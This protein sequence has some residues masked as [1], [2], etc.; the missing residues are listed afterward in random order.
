MFLIGASGQGALLRAQNRR[1]LDRS[2]PLRNPFPLW[3][4]IGEAKPFYHMPLQAPPWQKSDMQDS[5]LYGRILGIRDP[6][7]VERVDLQLQHGEVHVYL[8]HDDKP[9]W[10][11]AECGASCPSMI[12][13]PSGSGRICTQ[14]IRHKQSQAR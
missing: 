6:W 7:R 11:C 13:K 9:E 12:I 5:E 14:Y 2:T 10:P 4:E 8:T 1:A 3:K